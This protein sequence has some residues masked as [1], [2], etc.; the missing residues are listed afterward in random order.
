MRGGQRRKKDAFLKARSWRRKGRRTPSSRREKT[1]GR[2]TLV[3]CLGTVLNKKR[4][5]ILS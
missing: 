2:E 5:Y 3:S 1:V 4:G